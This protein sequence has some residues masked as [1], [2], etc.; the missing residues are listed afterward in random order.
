MDYAVLALSA[1]ILFV[2]LMLAWRRNGARRPGSTLPT[3]WPVATRALLSRPEQT[4]LRAAQM[5]FPQ[6]VAVPKAPLSR[7]LRL[8]QA[9]DTQ[10]LYALIAPQVVTLVLF[11]PEFM[12]LYCIDMVSDDQRSRDACLIKQRAL[13]AAQVPYVQIQPDAM[14]SPAALAQWL[15][16][17]GPD[18]EPATQ[19]TTQSV[20]QLQ[21]DS[22][23]SHLQDTIDSLRA[24]RERG[25][26]WDDSSPSQLPADPALLPRGEPGKRRALDVE[27]H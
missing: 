27:L 25:E 16:R 21:F 15:Q 3:Q 24:R 5:A 23:R 7:L 13:A 6:W 10:G 22:T 20:S 9:Q 26:P 11:S 4:L 18:A 8:Q 12:P 1:V 2:A 14:V 19:G 17:D